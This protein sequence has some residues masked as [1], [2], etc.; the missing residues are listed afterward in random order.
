V[1]YTSRSDKDVHKTF[2]EVRGNGNTVNS[3][4]LESALVKISAKLIDFMRPKLTFS[5]SELRPSRSQWSNS[6]WS[7]NSFT[8]RLEQTTSSTHIFSKSRVGGKIFEEKLFI[9]TIWTMF[10]QI[11]CFCPTVK[12]TVQWNFPNG[13]E[14][15]EFDGNFIPMAVTVRNKDK[16][17]EQKQNQNV[18]TRMQ[19]EYHLRDRSG[20]CFCSSIY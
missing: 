2:K 20:Y 8:P 12:K 1:I 17:T 7:L 9:L 4:Y 13:F 3:G 6:V 14:F 5:K 18:T 15:C 11:F 16:T 19:K 10:L